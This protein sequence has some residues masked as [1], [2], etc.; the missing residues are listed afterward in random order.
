MCIISYRLHTSA[1]STRC[2]FSFYSALLSK[3]L[4]RQ[5]CCEIK[6]EKSIQMVVLNHQF[7]CKMT[8]LAADIRQ[9]NRTNTGRF[10]Y[11]C[12]ANVSS[13]QLVIQFL[14]GVLGVAM[15]TLSPSSFARQNANVSHIFNLPSNNGKIAVFTHIFGPKKGEILLLLYIVKEL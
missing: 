12:L 4:F 3:R 10:W 6:D 9:L 5:K 2:F 8:D 11:V 14:G 1:Q 15:E 7:R 13:F